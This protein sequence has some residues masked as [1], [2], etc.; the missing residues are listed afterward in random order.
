M[1]MYW[2]RVC[3]VEESGVRDG[4]GLSHTMTC[5]QGHEIRRL[6]G[7]YRW[8]RSLSGVRRASRQI[9]IS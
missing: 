6:S 3:M 7:K 5:L 9:G 2:L 8:P 4:G 1:V